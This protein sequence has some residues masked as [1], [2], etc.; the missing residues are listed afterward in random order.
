MNTIDGKI[1]ITVW[2][3]LLRIFHW[4]LVFFVLLAFVTEDDWLYL[5]SFSGYAIIGLLVFRLCWGFIGSYHARF[6][7][8]VVSPVRAW[9][10]T[11]SLLKPN[12]KHYLGHNP[13]GAI[14][15]IALLLV[16]GLTVFSGTVALATEGLG[17]LASTWLAGLSGHWMEELHEAMANLLLLLIAI[18]LGGVVISSLLHRENLIRAMITGNKIKQ[19]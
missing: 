9:Q 16:L 8:F 15:I 1:E 7:N 17:P 19:E 12:P 14:M 13:A 5:H 6:R 11:T 18:H 2:D 10:Y 4:S 3:P